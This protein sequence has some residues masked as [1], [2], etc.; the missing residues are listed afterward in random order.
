MSNGFEYV[1]SNGTKMIL[2][3]SEDAN[4]T[5]TKREGVE[6]HKQINIFITYTKSNL[7]ESLP[8]TVI[9]KQ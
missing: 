7:V 9:S 3:D 2:P 1:D 8:I 4:D 6:L 5:C